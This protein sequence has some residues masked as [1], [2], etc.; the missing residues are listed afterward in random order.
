[1]IY[2]NFKGKQLSMLGFGLMRL[3]EK[4]GEIDAVQVEEM[5]DVAIKGGINYFDTAWPYHN[6]TSETVVGQILKKYPRDSFY[7]A[8]KFPGHQ[9]FKEFHPEEIFEK[10]LEKCQ[11]DYFDFYLMHNIC[12]NS[13]AD[14][15]D[16]RWGMLEYFVRQKREGRIRH[17]GMST[18]ASDE[19][20]REILDSEWGKETEF[21]QI[22]L[23]Y[24]DW[25]LQKAKEKVDIL[26]EHNIPI[27]VMEGLRGGLLAGDNGAT[28][29][30]FRWLQTIEGVTVVLS[31]MSNLEQAA[32]N[33]RIFAD[34]KT[35]IDQ[36][37]D[38]LAYN[39]TLLD[40]ALPCTACRYCV[41]ECPQG[42]DIPTLIASYND[43]KVTPKGQ[44][45]FTPL[46]LIESLDDARQ[47]KSCLGCDA[48]ASVCPQGIDIPTAMRDLAESFEGAKKWSE[49]CEERN[50]ITT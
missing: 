45:A 15:T 44:V 34:K 3:P 28:E 25:T 33:I 2:T 5:I 35:L 29:Q 43:M 16:K 12:E 24:V 13:L 30:A 38:S 17:L 21:C 49:I 27:W 8:D 1:M 23:N 11:V 47:P 26:R 19:T 40:N 20:L 4:N 14:Y 18:H 10:Q 36:E 6:G 7:L 32:D 48:C 22:Q 31:G 50:R 37:F 42:L 39:C 41:N 9:H 46:M